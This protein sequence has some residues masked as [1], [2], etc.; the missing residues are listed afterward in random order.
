MQ[1]RDN[2]RLNFILLALVLITAAGCEEDGP[3]IRL[4]PPQGQSGLKD[5]TFQANADTPAQTK[6][7]LVEDFTA[8]RCNNCP[9]AS[10]VIQTL[11]ATYGDSVI[12]LGIHCNRNLSRPYDE[13]QEGYR[14]PKGQTLYEWFGT[15]AQPSG[16]LDRFQYPNQNGVVVGYQ[17]WESLAPERLG[18]PPKANLYLNRNFSREAGEVKVTVRAR[19]REA[20]SETAYLTLLIT[21]D[22]IVDVQLGPEQKRPEYRHDHVV[23]YIQ[24]PAKGL[25]LAEAPSARQVVI[26]EFVMPVKSG[27]KIPDLN[28]VTF[29][30]LKNPKGPVLQAQKI[31]LN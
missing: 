14:I 15:P 2:M 25:Q 18:M 17:R 28:I 5:T 29:L 31:A 7:L 26:K 8:V 13:S 24:T 23:R 4:K 30:H 3:D 21:E 9:K 10:K 16:M 12:A 22:N 27:W 19:F 1:K 20:L 6:R 11:K